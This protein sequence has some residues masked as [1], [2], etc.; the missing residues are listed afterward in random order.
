[1]G[2]C[3]TRYILG[4]EEWVFSFLFF[5]SRSTFAYVYIGRPDNAGL[6]VLHANTS[7]EPEKAS[8][9][10]GGP[11]GFTQALSLPAVYTHSCMSPTICL[12]ALLLKPLHQ[13]HHPSFQ[14]F[15]LTHSAQN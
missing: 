4:I 6:A 13:S 3:P 1:M 12:K 10:S 5:F 9:S 14:E 7:Q 2:L 11:L 8:P 15:K